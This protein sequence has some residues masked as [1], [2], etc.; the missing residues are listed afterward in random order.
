M[1]KPFE[2]EFTYS[3]EERATV[4]CEADGTVRTI[5][6]SHGNGVTYFVE[7]VKPTMTM[8]VL[9]MEGK[10][11][12]SSRDAVNHPSHYNAGEVECID[13]IRAAVTSLDG[14]EGFCV[15]NA[16]KYLWRWKRKGGT[17]DLRKARW[18]LEGL[19]EWKEDTP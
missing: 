11:A 5:Q 15:G 8:R 6:Y 19:L 2:V 10:E 14:F 1:G 16:M 17:D 18:Y 4:F 3:Q 9:Q 12:T 7:K 13:A